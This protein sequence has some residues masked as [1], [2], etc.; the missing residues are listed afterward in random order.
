MPRDIL[1]ETVC[2]NANLLL[3]PHV[4]DALGTF[5]LQFVLGWGNLHGFV[6]EIEQAQDQRSVRHGLSPTLSI[7][8]SRNAAC[9]AST[10]ILIHFDY[11]IVPEQVQGALISPRVRLQF[12]SR[13]AA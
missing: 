11:L 6:A 4:T 9:D 2:S 12:S 1:R 3:T 10:W 13:G 8:E 7:A 5:Q